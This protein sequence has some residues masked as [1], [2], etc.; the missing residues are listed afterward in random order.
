MVSPNYPHRSYSSVQG[1]RWT[2]SAAR[3]QIVKFQLIDLGIESKRDCVADYLQITG[4]N[5][6][7]IYPSGKIKLCGQIENQRMKVFE[8]V[9]SEVDVEFVS[10]WFSS[11]KGFWL[12]YEGRCELQLKHRPISGILSQVISL[13]PNKHG[14]N[15]VRLFNEAASSWYMS[16]SQGCSI[17]ALLVSILISLTAIIAKTTWEQRF[18]SYK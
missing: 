4:L 3:G 14:A 9:N 12:K 17:I 16:E 7:M 10:D 13:L 6:D 15:G 5:S 2:L 1:C 8:T 11:D 18:L